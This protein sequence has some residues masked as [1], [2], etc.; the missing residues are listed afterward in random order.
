MS[1]SIL[2][3]IKDRLYC[4]KADSLERRSAPVSNLYDSECVNPSGC[5]DSRL[6][7]RRDLG[8]RCQHLASDDAE[9]VLFNEMRK[10]L[11]FRP[12]EGFVAKWESNPPDPGRGQ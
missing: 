7:F 4:E 1:I 9:S 3:I 12:D 8:L 5:A 10:R 11:N 2:D 6:Y